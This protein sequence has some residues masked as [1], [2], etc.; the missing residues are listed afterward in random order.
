MLALIT[1]MFAGITASNLELNAFWDAALPPNGVDKLLLRENI[2]L[3][4]RA[5]Y[6][7]ASPRAAIGGFDDGAVVAFASDA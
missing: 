1:S 5:G 4:K 7:G 2:A 3:R 6:L